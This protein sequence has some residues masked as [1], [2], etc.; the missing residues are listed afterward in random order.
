VDDETADAMDGE[1]H[2]GVDDGADDGVDDHV[3]RLPD[4]LDITAAVGPYEFP[5][6]GR[7]RI[8]GAIY[9]ATGAL[10]V[11]G[12]LVGR[13][14]EAVLINEGLLVTGVLLIVLG[15]VHVWTGWH[16]EHDDKDALVTATREVGF[17]VGHAAAQMGWRG[18]RSRPTWRILV[19]SADEP[20]SKR[21]LVLV[22]GVDGEVLD[23]IVEDNPATEMAMMAEDADSD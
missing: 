19:Y 6:N 8:P 2:D 1:Q 11:I 20:P 10:V 7:R 4:D 18:F 17:P 14:D 21:A 16:L 15:L 12:W 5:D 22:D 23:T 13:S 9:L 3:D